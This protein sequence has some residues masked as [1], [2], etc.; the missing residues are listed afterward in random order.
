MKASRA[1]AAVVAILL[2]GSSSRAQAPDP[3]PYP[4]SLREGVEFWKNVWA[5]WTMNQV[6]LH[7]MDR[8]SIV[9]EIFELP[10]PV[11]E[12]YT[13]AQREYV[14]GRRE[15]ISA[16]LTD[17]EEKIAAQI[18]LEDDEKA[19]VLKVTDVAGSGGLAGA[20]T[21]VSSQRGLRERFRRGLEVSG[22]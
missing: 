11:G 10:G 9:Y 13:E 5:K 22:R 7:D 14:K 12:T 2:A 4:D 1:L 8:P 17:I 18:P 6:V 21:R 16:R 15:A 19:L 3:L 20:G